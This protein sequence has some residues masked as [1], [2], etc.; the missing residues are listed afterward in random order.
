MSSAVPRTFVGMTFGRT[1][2][3]EAPKPLTDH[4]CE[5]IVGI[6]VDSMYPV[7][8]KSLEAFRDHFLSRVRPGPVFTG[9]PPIL[10]AP[11]MIDCAPVMVSMRSC[12]SAT[13]AKP[14]ASKVD[15]S[16]PRVNPPAIFPAAVHVS[17]M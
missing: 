3:G 14:C 8:G 2:V 1:R 13:M 15:G 12:D 5:T 17:T 16:P 10:M 9:T 11:A 6:T 4:K 7:V